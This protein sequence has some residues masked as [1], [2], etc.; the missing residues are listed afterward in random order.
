MKERERVK[1][2]ARER[3]EKE[4]TKRINAADNSRLT[5]FPS[6]ETKQT[7]RASFS[8]KVFVN[9]FFEKTS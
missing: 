5:L 6:L 1:E 4:S 9:F 7:S 3:G 2:S 8:R